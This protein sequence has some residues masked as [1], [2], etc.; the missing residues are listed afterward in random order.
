MISESTLIQS[1]AGITTGRSVL[2]AR[3]E[4]I[5]YDPI[6]FLKCVR[7][8]DEVDRQ[9]PIKDFPLYLAY[10]NLY[11]RLWQKEPLI[12]VPKSRRMK[13]SWTN[14]A[15]FLHD[16]MFNIG[17]NHAF[18]SKKEDDSDNLVKRA[19][20]IY[21]HLNFDLLPRDLIPV[22][23]PKYC[24]LGFKQIES[25][26]NGYP[27]GA[28]QL[29]QFTFSGLLFDEMA[30]WGNAREAYSSSYPTIEGG[31]RMTLISSP[32][33]GFFK[34]VI[35]DQ[36]DAL[37]DSVIGEE[38]ALAAERKF[39]MEGIEIWKNPNNQFVVFQ[40]HYTADPAKRGEEW[41]VNTRASMPIRD[42]KQEYE[43]QWDSFAGLPV[44]PDYDKNFHGSKTPLEPKAGLPLLRSW[45]FGLTPGVVIAQYREGTLFVLREF[46]AVNMGVER[47]ADQVLPQCAVLFRDWWRQEDWL[48]FGDPAG[49]AKTQ[50]NETTCAQILGQK[51]VSL[52]PGE[53]FFEDR[54]KAIE[55]LLIKRTKDG[56]GMLIDLGHCPVLA[57]GFAGGYRYQERILDKEPTKILPIKDEHS[58]VH[59]ALQY[60]ATRITTM[61]RGV[62]N[63]APILSY[64]SRR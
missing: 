60:M 23:D 54:K 14:I 40:I 31:G 9:N 17:R 62:F 35:F 33:P 47:F 36:I 22:K 51:G 27:S 45:D 30:F 2:L 25:E 8:K 53:L 3:F 18:V 26:I 44:F 64:S 61:R 42:F 46:T 63:K 7:T 29:R 24:H 4:K 58:H 56:P 6:E 49:N 57:R 21:D 13:M 39:P 10:L 48:D 28:D 55:K 50:T 12:A 37:E 19:E 1:S 5:K 11:I 20:F 15:L 41:R 52:I 34:R 59:D 32:A 16:A 38:S 43:L